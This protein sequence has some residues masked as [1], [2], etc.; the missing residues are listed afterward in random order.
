MGRP[1]FHTALLL[2]PTP[3]E[4]TSV[5]NALLQCGLENVLLAGE[6]AEALALLTQEP[7]DIVVTPWELDGLPGRALLRAL[8]QKGRHKQ[9]PVLI[10]DS[11]L[12]PQAMVAAVKAGA[13]G[14]LTL[15]PR[16][17]RLEK[18]LKT[19]REGWP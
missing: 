1:L 11:G 14:R 7:V 13:A 6:Q 18:L 16:R 15:P 2:A 12:T 19:V 17:S 5:R 3:V 4:G 8:K 9:V 10:L